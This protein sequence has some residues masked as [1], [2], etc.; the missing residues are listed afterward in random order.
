[1]DTSKSEFY[2]FGLL[3]QVCIHSLI[4]DEYSKMYKPQETCD[5]GH[6]EWVE[7]T[8]IMIEGYPP[9]QVHRC[10]KCNEVR[11]AHHIGIKEEH[12]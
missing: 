12:I 6:S 1:M 8:M 9:K 4:E 7:S 10:K 5:C 3:P 2:H 11:I